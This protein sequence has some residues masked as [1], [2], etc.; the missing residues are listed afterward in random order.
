M[1]VGIGAIFILPDFP[2]TW[3][4][5]TPEMKRVAIRRLAIDAAEADT[6]EAGGMSQIK[7][8]KLAFT[9]PKTYI[10][11]SPCCHCKSLANPFSS[12]YC[13]HGNYWLCRCVTNL[14]MYLTIRS[15]NVSR[16]PKLLPNPHRHFGLQPHHLASSCRAAIRLHGLLLIRPLLPLRPP[17]QPLLVPQLPRRHLDRRL[18][19]LHVHRRLRPALLLLLPDE[20]R[21]RPKR[22]NLRLDLKCHPTTARQACCGARFH[23]LHR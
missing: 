22:H 16:F 20:L 2:E 4:G 1:A 9:D 18:P 6:D 5:L 3:K 13:I 23:Q 11:L 12:R 15:D 21:L 7:G 19:H 10:R 14:H 17:R 8:M